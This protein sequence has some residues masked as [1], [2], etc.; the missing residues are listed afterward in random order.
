MNMAGPVTSASATPHG[1]QVRAAQASRAGRKAE[2]EDALGIRVPGDHQRN[3]KGVVL[4]I[5]DGVSGAGEGRRAAEVS[6]QGFLSDYFATPETWTVKTSGERVLSALN[7]W[8]HGQGQQYTQ[9]HHGFL[10]T[11]SAL[12]IR[13][14]TAYL[15]HI[16]DSRIQRLRQ[17][18]TGGSTLEPLT[19]DHATRVGAEKTYLTR[20]LG[21]DWQVEIDF[22]K[23]DVQAGDIFFLSTDGVH[24]FLPRPMLKKLLAGATENPEACCESILDIAYEAGSDDNLSCQIL[25]VDALAPLGADDSRLQ[26]A[27]LPLLP[28]L[29]PGQLIDGLR[30]EAEMHANARSQLYR[31]RDEK[32]GK[33]YALKTPSRLFEGDSEQLSRFAQ[34]DWIGQRLD[35]AHVVKGITP[36]QA[37]QSLY[38]LQEWL[39]GET[40]AQWRKKNPCPSAQQVAGFAEQAIKGLRALHRR[41]TL[42]QDIKPENLFLCTDGRLKVIDL[43]AAHVAG[44][45]D[46]PPAD[47]PGAAEYAAPEFALNLP[48]D[49]RAD[50]FSL[51]VTLYELLTGQHPFNNGNSS[52]YSNASTLADFQK[53]EYTSA[54]RYNPH[55]PL[56]FD[57]ALRKALSPSPASRYDSL[58]EFLQDLQKPNPALS[59]VNAQPWIERDPVGFWKVLAL[60]MTL[61]AVMELLWILHLR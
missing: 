57:A 9:A 5:A 29:A 4:A 36:R 22:R 16:G 15:F 48:R 53:L 30:V 59:P 49:A 54:C 27:T 32:S 34:E 17:D 35:H 58:G 25:V 2:N 55:V 26:A 13:S 8:L 7:R 39:E 47:R 12:V 10:T 33:R 1:L 51:A 31:V 38:L 23:T 20:A 21:M 52:G 18:A 28:D 40:L 37:R 61:L 24:E 42:H 6:V 11:F 45:S 41:E 50:Q 56:W 60:F 46:I 19:Q 43:G 3:A 44:M 14:Q